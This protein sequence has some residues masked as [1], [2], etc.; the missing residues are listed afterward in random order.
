MYSSQMLHARQVISA[1]TFLAFATVLVVCLVS[2]TLASAQKKPPNIIIILADDLGYGELGCYGHPKFKTPNLDALAKKGAKLNHLTTPMGFCAPTRA[3]LITGRYPLRN[4]LWK[5]PLPAEDPAGGNAQSD[6][7]GLALSE[8]TLA[9]LCRAAGYHTG[10][11]GKWHL[12]HQKQFLPLQRGF[13][14]YFGIPYSNDMH[15][16]KLLEGNKVVEYPVVQATL[17]KRY[18]DKALEFLQRFKGGPFLLMLWHAMPHKPLACSEDYYGKSG[19]GLYGDVMMEMDWSVGQIIARLRELEIDDNTLVIFTSDNGP[20]YGGSTGGLRGMKGTNWEGGCRVPCIACWP[21]HIPAG[22]TSN[23]P[24]TTCDLFTTALTA[25]KIGLP[26]N[27][28]IDGK[29]LWPLFTD[30]KAKSPHAGVFTF[31]GDKLC[32]VRHGQWKLYLMPPAAKGKQKVWKPTDEWIDPR[33]PNG[34]TILAPYE[35]AHPSQFPGL[36][37]GDEVTK[38]GLF[39]LHADPGEQRNVIAMHPQVV[40]QLQAL[41]AVWEKTLGNGK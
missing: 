35:Q 1:K 6:A 10:L 16:V 40:Q 19:A 33:R 7:I 22:H 39:D 29:D 41:A 38:M 20:W 26:K 25:A 23:E 28:T 36:L 30:P 18:T 27:R 15:K 2:P 9:Q 34:V 13:D 32:S 17:T 24:A 37:S 8:L 31:R 3:A 12:G 21:G 5:N 11:I 4:G 14:E